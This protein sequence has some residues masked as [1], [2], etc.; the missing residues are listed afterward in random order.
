MRQPLPQHFPYFLILWI[1]PAF[2]YLKTL[3][4]SLYFI[5]AGATLGGAYTLG[6][7]TPPGYPS[8]MVIAHIFTKIPWGT[9]LFRIQLFSILSALMALTMV[10]TFINKL[11]ASGFSIYKFGGEMA[12]VTSD[13]KHV[14]LSALTASLALAFSY[15]FW[16]QTL[17]IQSY[18]FTDFLMLSTLFL[19][20]Y[21]KPGKMLLQLGAIAAFFITLASGGSAVM[22]VTT[23]AAFLLILIYYW[24]EIGVGKLCLIGLIGLIGVAIVYSYLPIRAHARPFLNWGNPQTPQLFWNH[25]HSAGTTFNDPITGKVVGYNLSLI[26]FIKAVRKYFELLFWQFTPFLLPVIG[27][28]IYQLYKRNRR[29]FWIL[30]S[31]PLAN[32]VYGGLVISGNRESWFILSYIIFS[33]FLGIGIMWMLEQ[34]LS[35]KREGG[36]KLHAALLV[37]IVLLPLGW[38]FYKINPR[39]NSHALTD[40]ANNL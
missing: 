12:H 2:V 7:P 17:N 22:I 40:Y 23:A 24:D 11:F 28:G 1:L 30:A 4:P 26:E 33:L 29:L 15:Q 25:V 31:V 37:A 6:I 3:Q 36:S 13:T 5:D 35:G 20:F 34:G 19:V 14:R 39:S 18:V 9:P 8:Y 21:V 16:S 32:I 27:V 38:W 10:Y